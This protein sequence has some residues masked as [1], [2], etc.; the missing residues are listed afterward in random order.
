MSDTN[1]HSELLSP[2][3]V[4]QARLQTNLIRDD[5]NE[6][7]MGQEDVVDATCIGLLARGHVL[8][9]GLPGLGKTELVK[10]LGRLLNLDFTR[11]QFTPDLLPA[12]ITGS[13]ILEDTGKGTRDFQFRA[14]PVFGNVVLADEINRASPKTQAALLEAMQEHKVTL[15]GTTHDLPQPFFVLATQNPIELEGTYPLPEAQLDRFLFKINIH[16]LQPETL[17]RILLER[18]RGEPPT[19][20]PVLDS[21]ELTALFDTVDQ[22]HLP[23]AVASYIS[24]LVYATTPTNSQAPEVVR[25]L[26]RYGSSPR[27][28]IG[29]A[30][31][32]RAAAIC[33]GKPNVGFEEVNRV[34][35]LV[36]RHRI[37]LNYEAGLEKVDADQIVAAALTA[38]DELSRIPR[39]LDQ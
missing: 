10:G 32:G 16:D 8:L 20:A 34:A 4:E 13:Y 24:R 25:R 35:P 38:T 9:E 23:K 15:L 7:L 6:V 1:G 31:A 19:L 14:G 2:E 27:A 3:R 28:A 36:L 22:V 29:I 18:Q 17:T 39:T 30:N 21:S 26:V 11:I 5:L 12:D 37:V 33:E